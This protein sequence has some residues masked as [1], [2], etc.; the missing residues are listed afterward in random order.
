MGI[1][2]ITPILIQATCCTGQFQI[3]AIIRIS[4]ALNRSGNSRMGMLSNASMECSRIPVVYQEH[5]VIMMAKVA[6]YMRHKR[7]NEFSV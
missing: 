4:T 6:Q 7:I 1:L 3:F 2:G 5:V